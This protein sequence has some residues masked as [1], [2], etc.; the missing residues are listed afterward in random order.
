[1]N[2]TQQINIRLSWLR[3]ITEKPETDTKLV[4]PGADQRGWVLNDMD[5]LLKELGQT[6][7]INRILVNENA[8]LREQ[9]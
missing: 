8:R 7:K 6:R 2:S 4:P 5:F 1:M 9:L 3:R